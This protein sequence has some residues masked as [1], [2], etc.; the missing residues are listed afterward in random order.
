QVWIE[1]KVDDRGRLLAAIDPTNAFRARVSE[2]I[3]IDL[4]VDLVRMPFRRLLGCLRIH[5][6]VV[7]REKNADENAE[8]DNLARRYVFV[9]SIHL[10]F[11]SAFSAYL[12]AL[13]VNDVLKTQRAQ[14]YAENAE[15]TLASS[16]CRALFDHDR[17]NHVVPHDPV[18]YVHSGYHSSKHR[19]ASVE[20]RLRR[21][22]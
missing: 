11:L 6:L 10:G 4:Q 22:C 1:M 19:V 2:T 9:S 12:C 8:H 7:S 18:N 15:K 20:M 5:L 21:V 17:L 14:R 16:A 13:G 3:E